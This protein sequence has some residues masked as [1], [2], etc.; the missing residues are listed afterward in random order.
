[1]L[2]VKY[3]IAELVCGPHYEE[4]QAN[5]EGNQNNNILELFVP[6]KLVNDLMDK[7]SAGTGVWF[8]A[9]SN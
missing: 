5:T 8:Y 4:I 6:K 3:I 9:L 1:M 2:C 7:Q